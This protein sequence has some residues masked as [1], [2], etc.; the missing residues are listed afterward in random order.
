M[1]RVATPKKSIAPA[2]GARR[3]TQANAAPAEDRLHI[4]LV[5]DHFDTRESI[6]RLLEAASHRVTTAESAEEALKLAEATAFD[7]VLSDLGLPDMSG[8]ELMRRLQ[9]RFNLPGIALSG[10]GMQNDVEESRKSG[11]A[12]HLTKPVSFDR[13]KSLVAEVAKNRQKS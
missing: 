5:E 1:K 13:L 2:A 6:R 8:N 9:A 4:L 12:Y 7:V 11:F 10:Y 3:P